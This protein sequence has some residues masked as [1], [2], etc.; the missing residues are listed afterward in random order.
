[1]SSWKTVLKKAH[2]PELDLRASAE[3]IKTFKQAQGAIKQSDR[4][5]GIAR[6]RLEVFDEVTSGT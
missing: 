2:H 3:L 6:D 1:M 5:N 4:Q